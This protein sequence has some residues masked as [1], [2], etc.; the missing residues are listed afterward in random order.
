MLLRASMAIPQI[1]TPMHEAYMLLDAYKEENPAMNPIDHNYPIIQMISGGHNRFGV[2][3]PCPQRTGH[4][5]NT[6][7]PVVLS[8]PHVISDLVEDL[9]L[10]VE[11]VS[12]ARLQEIGEMVDEADVK[13]EE[14]EEDEKTPLKDPLPDCSD[15]SLLAKWPKGRLGNAVC[16]MQ[17][18][19]EALLVN[20]TG[21]DWSASLKADSIRGFIRSTT[22]TGI[23][24]KTSEFPQLLKINDDQCIVLTHLL[25]VS[26]SIACLKKDSRSS[27]WLP[28]LVPIQAV[29]GFL[30]RWLGGRP[31]DNQLLIFKAFKQSLRRTFKRQ[32]DAGANPKCIVDSVASDSNLDRPKFAELIYVSISILMCFDFDFVGFICGMLDVLLVLVWSRHGRHFG[33]ASR[34]TSSR[35]LWT[36]GSCRRRLALWQLH[37]RTVCAYVTP[38]QTKFLCIFKRASATPGC[39][40]ACL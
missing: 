34:R 20:I 30:K 1:N 15:S 5:A 8:S 9:D 32:A 27:A 14:M 12:S 29:E 37:S 28:F 3:F 23:E 33:A 36:P 40:D 7:G 38:H 2:R 10:L 16:K 26:L 25:N 24:L 31:L 19:V 17:Q 21:K 18:K 39:A 35:R 4:A 13:A 6:A 11:F 22:G